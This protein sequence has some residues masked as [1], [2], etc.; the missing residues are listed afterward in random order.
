MKQ[1]IYYTLLFLVI[2]AL[3]HLLQKANNN[4]SDNVQNIISINQES[5][6]NSPG[7]LVGGPRPSPA[8]FCKNQIDA[9]LRQTGDLTVC[10][11]DAVHYPYIVFTCRGVGCPA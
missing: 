11:T 8:L 6:S 2:F 1:S 4:G 10:C 7:S 3:L 9:C 5:N